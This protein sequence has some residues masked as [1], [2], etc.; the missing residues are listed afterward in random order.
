MQVN[1]AYTQRYGGANGGNKESLD[2]DT[3]RPLLFHDS[4]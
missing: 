4:E 1:A 3:T 2:G